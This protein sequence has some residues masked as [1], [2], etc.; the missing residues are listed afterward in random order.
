MD[1]KR[2]PFLPLHFFYFEF[3][4]DV[5]RWFWVAIIAVVLAAGFGFFAV[6]NPTFWSLEVQ[7]IGDFQEESVKLSTIENVYRSYEL[8]AHAYKQHVSFSAGPML[9]AEVPTAIFWLLQ[10]LGWAFVLTATSLIRSRWS[11]LFYFIFILFIHFSGLGGMLIPAL[12]EGAM[13]YI[14]DFIVILPFLALAYAFQ[15]NALKWAF[16]G[17]FAV[18]FLLLGGGFA[19]VW[20]QHGWVALHELA[21]ESYFA[22]VFLAIAFFFFIAK[23]PTNLFMA[24]ANNRQNPKNRLGLGP[25]IAIYVVWTMATLIM[26]NEYIGI[27]FLP[28]GFSWGLKAIHV[29]I[30]AGLI[31]VF[32]SQNHF[33][34]VKTAFTSNTVYSFLV[35]GG[36]ILTIS[37]LGLMASQGDLAFI[38]SWDRLAAIFLFFVGL[39]HTAYIFANHS[40]LIRKKINLYYLL[41]LSTNYR[42]VIVWIFALIGVIVMEGR[43]SWSMEH[44]IKHSFST[45]HGD[46]AHLK[47]MHGA[48]LTLEEK[49]ALETKRKNAYIYASNETVYSAKAFHNLGYFSL[50]SVEQLDESIQ[51][52]LQ[53]KNFPYSVLNAA[54]LYV[55][56]QRP[57]L[58]RELLKGEWKKSQHPLI[59]N[60]LGNLYFK[61]EQP[62]SAIHYLR[63]ALLADLN[64]SA[65]YANL[66]L[67]YERYDRPEE[68]RQFL[69]SAVNSKEPSDAALTNAIA[70]Q[71]T[72]GQTLSMPEIAWEKASYNLKFNYLLQLL[73]SDQKQAAKELVK[74]FPEEENNADAMILNAFMMFQQ[75]SIENAISRFEYVDQVFV[76]KQANSYYALA[77]AYLE[78]GVTEMAKLYFR[79]AGDEGMAIAELYEAQMEMTMGHLDTAYAKLSRV[80]VDHEELWEAASKEIAILFLIVSYDNPLYAMT[81]FDVSKLTQEDYLR[82]GTLADSTDSYIPALENFRKAIAMDSSDHRPYLEMS[83]IYNRYSDPLAIVNLGY[84]LKVAPEE[85]DLLLELSRAYLLQGKM[86]SLNLSLNRIPQEYFPHEK[87]KIIAQRDLIQGD[88]ASALRILELEWKQHPLDQEVIS[89][90]AAIYTAQ[91][92]Y[93]AGNYLIAS[94]LALNR[95]NPNIWYYYA[96]F[97]R[98]WG[99]ARDAGFGA[100]RAIELSQSE[101]RK[102]ALQQEFQDEILEVIE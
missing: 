72:S 36:S 1:F 48:D 15:V 100:L 32:T 59:A 71:L 95:E 29:M 101:A 53:T 62:D 67:V 52:Y 69:Q 31:S 60:N 41:T 87:N 24:L 70:Y 8:T 49:Q 90:L 12:S 20:F 74:S 47:L 61:A 93:D 79:K 76:G 46:L 80:R 4:H 44:R 22:E 102:R 39:G 85:P 75:D 33:H 91:A 10:L 45:Q 37:H 66:A 30:I 56:G 35:M 88:T 82:I 42:F 9:A 7:E 58:A 18:F 16:S 65:A 34:F 96:V 13:H 98:A 14:A 84:G 92:N 43:S 73:A 3:G 51:L 78:Q 28:K 26:A 6:E 55:V 11:F 19:A 2:L 25:I 68:A 94:S 83:R 17:R 21:T 86:D 40:P 97:S 54:N 77:L 64:F 23:E 50:T 81:E 38:D 27:P 99:Q 63:Q 89:T 57:E 5:K